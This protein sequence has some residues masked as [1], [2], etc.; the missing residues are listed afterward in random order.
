VASG[1]SIHT[2]DGF[3]APSRGLR[4]EVIG[5]RRLRAERFDEDLPAQRRV[6]QLSRGG[7]ALLHVGENV[8]GSRLRDPAA[9]AQ[10]VGIELPAIARHDLQPIDGPFG[11]EVEQGLVVAGFPIGIG[12]GSG[13]TNHAGENAVRQGHLAKR[14]PMSRQGD[15]GHLVALHPECP[16]QLG[17]MSGFGSVGLDDDVQSRDR[18]VGDQP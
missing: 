6:G 17:E 13:C 3:V 12:K 18:R 15:G 11:F 16:G 2:G 5:R 1:S 14:V 9:S 7:A 10:G 4:Q 8:G